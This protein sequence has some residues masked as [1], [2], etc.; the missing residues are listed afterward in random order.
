MDSSN[1]HS[2]KDEFQQISSSLLATGAGDNE[3]TNIHKRE[4]NSIV[5]NQSTASLP[6]STTTESMGSPRRK[7]RKKRNKTTTPPRKEALSAQ[8]GEHRPITPPLTR[9]LAL[10]LEPSSSRDTEAR[11]LSRN[12]RISMS[13]ISTSVGGRGKKRTRNRRRPKSARV[14]QKQ[15]AVSTEKGVE[16]KP[17]GSST[18]HVIHEETEDEVVAQSGDWGEWDQQCPWRR[19][20]VSQTVMHK[21][22]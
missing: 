15:P 19:V 11:S 22:N 4:L 6:V 1:H 10:A 21:L 2:S 17:P 8:S 18:P 7:R 9:A 12:T 3:K 13:S 5:L 16:P 14:Q 20:R